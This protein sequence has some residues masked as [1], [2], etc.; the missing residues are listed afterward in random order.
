MSSVRN[1][2]NDNSLRW[3]IGY[4][5]SERHVRT[6]TVVQVDNQT[7]IVPKRVKFYIRG[8]PGICVRYG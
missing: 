4:T 6:R 8:T 7:P 1:L 5:G 2:R 3:R